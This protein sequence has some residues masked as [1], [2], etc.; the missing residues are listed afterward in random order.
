MF[1]GKDLLGYMFLFLLSKY[2]VMGWLGYTIGT[3]IT[4]K[5]TVKQFSKVLN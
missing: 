3:F 5:E 1:V 4:F 2:L